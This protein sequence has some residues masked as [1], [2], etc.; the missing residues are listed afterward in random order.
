MK[1]IRKKMHGRSIRFKLGIVFMLAS[2]TVFVVNIYTYYNANRAMGR[3]D[4]VYSSNIELNQLSE[5]LSNLQKNLYQYL[6][7][8]S[9]ETLEAYYVF[10]Q[11]YYNLINNLE[12]K[13]WRKIKK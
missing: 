12:D 4:S 5:T 6:N 3:M 2:C 11:D 1:E 7:T 13:H 9:S 10:E 8:K